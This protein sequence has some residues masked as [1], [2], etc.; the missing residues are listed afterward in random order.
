[1]IRVYI[2]HQEH[3]FF[4]MGENKILSVIRDNTQQ[5]KKET[6]YQLEHTCYVRRNKMQAAQDPRRYESR[7]VWHHINRCPR[8]LPLFLQI[9]ER[10]Y[11][12]MEHEAI[13]TFTVWQNMMDNN[14][15]YVA[16]MRVETGLTRLTIHVSMLDS[17]MHQ[18]P[19]IKIHRSRS[20]RVWVLMFFHDQSPRICRMLKMA[21]GRISEINMASMEAVLYRQA[22]R[23]IFAED[24]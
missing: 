13:N 14:A 22:M 20:G 15:E 12:T 21:A 9:C 4:S 2:E 19:W 1:M 24:W 6:K 18:I 5:K 3:I 23:S 11:D 10:M 7:T 16:A 8:F 17:L